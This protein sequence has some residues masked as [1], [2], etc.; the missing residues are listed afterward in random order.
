MADREQDERPVGRATS[1]GRRILHAVVS[2]AAWALFVWAW[3]VVFYR[4]TPLQTVRGVLVLGVFLVLVNVITFIWVRHNLDLHRRM[5]ARRGLPLVREEWG[6]DYFG[7]RLVADWLQIQDAPL[8][9]LDVDEHEKVFTVRD[10]RG[11]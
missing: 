9:D 6:R 4:R 10:P 11:S 1:R 7:R 5:G 8:I 3:Y 2:M